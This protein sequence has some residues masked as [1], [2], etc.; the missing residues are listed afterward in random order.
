MPIISVSRGTFSGGKHLAEELA[1]DLG[2]PCIS[3]EI[4][5][6]AAKRYEQLA[7]LQ[8]AALSFYRGKQGTC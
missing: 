8:R 7:T 5:T 1:Q 2:Y 6:D 4:I 3:R